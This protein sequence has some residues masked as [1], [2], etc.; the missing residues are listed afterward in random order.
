MILDLDHTKKY[1]LGC[2]FG[3]DSMALFHMLKKG[4]YQF[5]VAHVN[6][7]LRKESND[8]M[9]SLINYCQENN[10]DI[11]TH[12]VNQ[13]LKHNIEAKCREIRYK[14]FATLCRQ[15]N[16]DFVLVGHHQDDLLETFLLQKARKS[17]VT[18]YG[19]KTENCIDGV[20]VL[21]PLL[22]YKKADLLS[23]CQ[24]NNIPFAIDSS[25]LSDVYERNK[26]R[27]HVIENMNDI[28]RQKL[29]VDIHQENLELEKMVNE[30]MTNDIHFCSYLL[31]LNPKYL[32]YAIHILAREI[33]EDAHLS[34][35]CVREIKNVLLSEKPNIEMKV[36][37]N[38][39]FIKSYNQCNFRLKLQDITYSYFLDKPGIIDNKYFY[40]D[41]RHSS[42]DR[43]INLD[44]YPLTVRN[45]K[46]GDSTMIKDY[47]VLVRRLFIDWKMPIELRKRWPV[48]L[49]KNGTIVYVPRYQKDFV[50]T[51]NINFYVK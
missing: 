32:A 13:I 8:E 4:G 19:L 29:L 45:I 10:I 46:R 21:R 51:K 11:Y 31:T 48:I 26:I 37:S 24:K 22:M 16:F 18:Y 40:L 35:S 2:S 27:H 7:G 25:N 47:R 42:K 12:E 3:P 36:N 15:N 5:S 34:S 20:Y 28:E 30:L 17:L 23:Y 14:F 44:D 1:L 33:K 38:L 50:K 49:N 43:N 41:F 39:F 9:H 6:Y